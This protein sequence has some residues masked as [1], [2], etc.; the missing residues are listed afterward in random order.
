MRTVTN[1]ERNT[2]TTEERE[3]LDN[4]RVL[5]KRGKHEVQMAAY[6]QL[7]RI[8]NE[9]AASRWEERESMGQ[10]QNNNIIHFKASTQ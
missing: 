6:L 7:E 4:Y 5:D 8:C 2:V 10:K 3:L 9:Y 1:F